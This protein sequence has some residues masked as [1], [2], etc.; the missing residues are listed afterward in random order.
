MT[1]P[2]RTAEIKVTGMT[3]VMC[4]KA[5]K[6]ALEATPG[7]ASAEI[8][9]GRETA[10]VVFDPER[11]K[12]PGLVA[13]IR[14]AGYEVALERA[15]VRIGGMTCVM[16]VKAVE[17][18]LK[19][20]PGV[21]EATVSLGNETANVLYNPGLSSPADMKSAVEAAGYQYLG[22]SGEVSADEE[23]SA[24]A[25][26][27]R[28]KLIRLSVGFA[29]S[30][31]LMAAMH[32][33]LHWPIDESYAYFLI[34]TPAF[35]Y[36]GRPIFA[37]A[38]RAL[39][40]RNLN[41]DVMY[42]MGIGT[43]YLASVM[44]TFGVVLSRD[45]NFYDTAVMLAAFLTL[46]RYLESRARGKTSQAIKALM[47][48]KPK[49]ATIVRDGREVEVA[50]EDVAVGDV[51]KVSPGE[52]V[53]VDGLVTDGSSHVDESM[54]TGEPAPK[55]K[56]RGDGVVGGTL[57]REGVL[58]FRAGKVGRETLLAQI[59]RL[60]EV[61][62]GSKPP[63]Q[64]LADKVV[65]WFIPFVLAVAALAFVFWFL[66]VGQSFLFSLTVLISIMVI[67]CPCALGLATPTAVTVG[68]GRGAEMGVLIKNGQAL[69]IPGR[70]TAVVFDKTGT[71]TAGRP[72]VTDLIPSPELS[73]GQREL[74][75]LAFS[76]ERH[77]KHPLAEAVTRRAREDGV[78]PGQAADFATVEGKGLRGLV[79][80]QPVA[81]GNRA[82]FEET[83]A[84]WDE[85][86]ERGAAAL[87]AQGKTVAAL[88]LD[89]RP[90]GLIGIADT[91]KP[92]SARAVAE[93]KRM[94]LRTI[95]LTGDNA[96]TAEAIAGQLGLDGFIAQ[97]LPADKAARVR[98]LQAE[99]QVVA[100]VGDGI[101]DA[102]AL[103]QADV[104]IAMGGGSDVALESGDIVL[105][106]DDLVDAVAA[107]QLSRQVM[108]RIRQ[109]LFWA[110]A[111]NTALIPVA[112]G[113]LYSWLGAMV[114]PELAGLAMAMSSV[115]VVTLSL[116]LK[117]YTP[118][119][120][121]TAGV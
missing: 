48:L 25:R 39:R 64:L 120:K 4:V 119:V 27:Q 100:F 14:E 91:L 28:D 45:F 46:G 18:A 83:G 15:A 115:T 97:V 112:A 21:A 10:E 40:N 74:L 86:L 114:K 51:V 12:L 49:T 72:A 92:T 29:V 67:A 71:L 117:A 17:A 53:P 66:L 43:A 76:L 82:V 68:L 80:G 89:G 98:Q 57:N 22:L 87:E 116:T 96:R 16:C 103:A 8:N 35:V 77:S 101:N 2:T 55:S 81:V 95:M 37:A 13:A 20:L 11:V 6:A 9:L 7:V 69:E 63:V 118:P 106:H 121:R 111:Y 52:R 56:K 90:A 85:W 99:G 23:A 108:R 60:V 78:E 3:C 58:W 70:L 32:F 26:D 47:G 107:V 19:E 36:L 109:N 88:A 59:I 5:V 113:A 93:F 104:G 75:R 41:M 62:Q 65:A 94:G 61:A 24:R 42:A 73:G 110:F 34:S 31:P 33:H 105:M 102:P 54:I 38:W 50:T 84:R 30:V 44:G 1:S 79:D